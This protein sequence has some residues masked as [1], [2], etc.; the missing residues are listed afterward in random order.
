MNKQQELLVITMEECAELGQA[1][2]KI[3]RFNEDDVLDVDDAC[4]L[5]NEVGDVLCMIELLKERGLIEE[6]KIQDRILEKRHKLT[7]WSNLFK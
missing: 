3:I 1:C 6:D 2:S 5:Q 7:R 4:N